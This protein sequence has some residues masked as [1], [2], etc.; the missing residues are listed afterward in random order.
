[1]VKPI[2]SARGRGR[3]QGE[4]E[5][6]LVGLQVE[7]RIAV[8][9]LDIFELGLPDGGDALGHLDAGAG[10]LAGGDVLEEVGRL[11]GQRGDARRLGAADALEG[12]LAGLRAGAADDA[13]AGEADAH[14]AAGTIGGHAK[15]FPLVDWAR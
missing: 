11:A 6:D 13:E 14:G 1:L 4:G 3:V 9:A 15:Q 5:V 2:D 8:G 12:A 10:P 7:H